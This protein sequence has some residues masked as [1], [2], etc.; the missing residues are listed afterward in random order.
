[1]KI[2]ARKLTQGSLF[3][4]I[5]IGIS[6]SFMPFFLICGVAS[7]FGANTVW[8]EQQPVTGF[9]G[10]V[11]ALLMY[12]PFCITL[13][14]LAWLCIAFGLWIYSKFRKIE[15]SFVDAEV[16][17]EEVAQRPPAETAD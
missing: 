7:I 15:L 13:S 4:L 16:I 6:I 5:L 10:L 12:P 17:D 9:M 2:C 3:K 11:T 8:S 1:M 14:C